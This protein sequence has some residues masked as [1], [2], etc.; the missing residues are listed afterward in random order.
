MRLGGI[1]TSGSNLT[2]E[3]RKGFPPDS[4]HASLAHVNWN[5]HYSHARGSPPSGGARTGAQC[6]A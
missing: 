5:F 1:T 4:T 2:F 3:S 6:A